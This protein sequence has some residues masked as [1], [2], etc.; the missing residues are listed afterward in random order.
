LIFNLYID[1]DL[2]SLFA[3][4]LELVD[5]DSD[6]TQLAKDLG[7]TEREMTPL[8][9]EPDPF[10]A[11]LATYAARGGT[12][13]ELLRAMY[14]CRRGR[15]LATVGASPPTPRRR[16]LSHSSSFGSSLLELDPELEILEEAALLSPITTPNGKRK[17]SSSST[18]TRKRSRLTDDTADYDLDFCDAATLP[19]GDLDCGIEQS[20]L[21]PT[22]PATPLKRVSATS[23]N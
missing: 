19:V 2:F 6:V 1:P 8:E 17:R 22:P 15:G 5:E 20:A 21:P 23:R 18:S 13:Q 16:L 14:S 4:L 12:P 7:F 11:L 3:G 10:T 9:T